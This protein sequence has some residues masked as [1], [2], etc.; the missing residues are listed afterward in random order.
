MSI[1]RRYNT[2]CNRN[3]VFP[4]EGPSV[5][6]EKHHTVSISNIRDH[7]TR[8]LQHLESRCTINSYLDFGLISAVFGCFTNA[9]APPPIPLESCAK[10]QK[11]RQVFL[12]AGGLQTFCEWRHNWSSFWA[13]LAHI[14]WP[15]AQPLGQS[16]SLKFSLETRHESESFEHLIDFLAFLVQKLWFKINKLINYRIMGLIKYFVCFRS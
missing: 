9:I 8:S 12:S 16:I 4:L 7:Q 14:S 13:I 15:R 6:H 11:I 2:I 10:S 1:S 3:L 5:K